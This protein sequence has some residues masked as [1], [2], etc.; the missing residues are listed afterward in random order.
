MDRKP[1]VLQVPDVAWFVDGVLEIGPP[2]LPLQGLAELQLVE[3][4]GYHEVLRNYFALRIPFLPDVSV[5]PDLVSQSDEKRVAEIFQNQIYFVQGLSK[6]KGMAFSLRYYWRPSDGR[7][8]IAF[9]GKVIANP[10][11]ADFVTS[12]MYKDI[13]ITLRNLDLPVEAV[14]NERDLRNLINPHPE[15]CLVVEVRQHEEVARM[16]YG[17]AYVIHPYSFPSTTWVSAFRTLTSQ[18]ESCCIN[19]HLQPTSLYKVE[20]EELAR[21]ALIAD[22]LSDFVERRVVEDRRIKDP[23]A[24]FVAR[25]YSSLIERLTNPYLVVMQ[26]VSPNH[27]TARNVAQTFANESTGR[28]LTEDAVAQGSLASSSFDLAIPRSP[29]ELWAAHQTLG[30]LDLH[31]WGGIDP[32]PGKERLRYLA[33]A[34][35]ATC[36]FRFPVPVR[37]GIP[38]IQTKVSLPGYD[39]G[40][41]TSQVPKDHITIGTMEKSGGKVSV[42]LNHLSRHSLI[43]GTTGYGKTTTCMHL[44]HQ[45]WEKSIPFLVI[46]PT[47]NQYRCLIDSPMGSELRVFTLGDESVSPFRLNPLEILP[48]TRVESHI[49]MLQTCLIA[50]LPTFGV[51]PILIEQSLHNVYAAKGWAMT[52]KGRHVEDR[53]MPT[54]GDLYHEIVRVVDEI[55]YAENT[56]RDIRGAAAARIGSLL[57]GSKGRMLNTRRSISM[58]SLMSQPTVLEL[59]SLNDDE[60]ALVMM[61]LFTMIREYC[62]NERSNSQLQHVTVIEEAHRVMSVS[63]QAINPEIS[64]ETRTQAAAM[65]SSALSEIRKFGEG[66]IVVEQIPSR[67]VDDAMKNTNIKIVH[68]ILGEDDQRSLA[69]TMN[70]THGDQRWTLLRHGQAAVFHEGLEAPTTVVVPNFRHEQRLAE[71]VHDDRIEARM[72]GVGLTEDSSHLPFDGCKYCLRQCQYRDRVTNLVYD[73]RT[74]SRF[75]QALRD[76]EELHRRR[77]PDRAWSR[78]IQSCLEAAGDG[79]KH[80]AFCYFAHLW[81]GEFT[82]ALASSVMERFESE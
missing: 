21:A 30:T 38:G 79:D 72:R 46:E 50:S 1:F 47:N 55:G 73:V 52:D 66:L 10:N 18:E 54:L 7:V 32:T 49:S 64:P 41:R 5:S 62:R 31:P 57:V 77:E 37:G 60:K 45:L 28:R 12:E 2:I 27:M 76:F 80:A 51:L 8:E 22:S 33:D 81:D 23:T 4:S 35:A 3:I 56:K 25:I 14:T 48:G 6:W 63:R 11:R 82:Q 58:R 67:L 68:R 39:P 65:F 78:L 20:R 69:N 36:V 29:D 53:I 24:S 16:H 44:L 42:P 61:V 71:H 9:I 74:E 26:V 13:H 34:K 40:P 19:V 59:E 70:T 17:E 43:V 75:R 15:H